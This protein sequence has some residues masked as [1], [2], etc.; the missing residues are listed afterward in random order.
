MERVAG[1]HGQRVL[2]LANETRT[3]LVLKLALAVPAPWQQ[4]LID[5][6]PRYITSGDDSC[7]LC[8]RRLNGIGS[9]SHQMDARQTTS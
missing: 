9:E 5:Q 7:G 2:Q 4:R 3:L 6:D 1:Y 8:M